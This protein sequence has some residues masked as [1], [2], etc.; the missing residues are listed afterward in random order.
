L[1]AKEYPRLDDEWLTQRESMKHST[2]LTLLTLTLALVSCGDDSAT[3]LPTGSGGAPVGSGGAV[4]GAGGAVGGAG[5]A[6]VG[7]GGAVIGAGG[8]VI[9][10]GGAV[11]GAGG[12][13]VGAGGAIVGAGGAIVGAGGAIIG[14]GGAVVGAGGAVVGTG[15]TPAGTGGAGS[16][17][18]LDPI[19]PEISGDCPTFKSGTSTVTVMGSAATVIAGAQKQGTGSLLFYWYGTGKLGDVNTSLPQAIKTD[20]ASQGGIVFALNQAKNTGGDCSGTGTWGIDDFKVADQVAA[21]AVKNYGIDPKRIYA[22]GCSAGGLTTGCMGIMRSNYI[23]AVAP[24]SGGVTIGYGKLQDPKRVPNAITMNGGSGDN[25]IVNFGDTSEGYDNYILHYG[26]FA[27]NCIHNSGHCGAPAALYGS[28]WQFL[29][30]HPFGTKPSPYAAGLPA[31]FNST[32]KIF[33]ATSKAP[34]GGY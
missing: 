15:G 9:G 13:I 3:D 8:A 1:R 14:A 6:V 10:T 4:V 34:L 19:I 16:V 31:G 28:A 22:T 2:P 32:C 18:G 27:V 12:A 33:T 17:G 25:V 30:D 24:N 20:V 29:K 21:C 7:A 11:V 23:A 26:G 5:G